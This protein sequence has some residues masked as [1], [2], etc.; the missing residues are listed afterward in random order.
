MPF[1]FE[2]KVIS[3]HSET[4]P[5]DNCKTAVRFE[6]TAS[7][8]KDMG[9]QHISEEVKLTGNASHYHSG[10]VGPSGMRI[11]EFIKPGEHILIHA[12]SKTVDGS[13]ELTHY[14]QVTRLPL[15]A[16]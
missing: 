13:F 15:Q 4:L 6:V 2:A 11:F 16:P 14:S 10:C 5:S 3:V 8:V 9:T 12:N 1:K 7:K